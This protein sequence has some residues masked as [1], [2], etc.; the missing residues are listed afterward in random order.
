[1]RRA[2]S[3]SRIEPKLRGP[4]PVVGAG[5]PP[6]ELRQLPRAALS[7]MAA[8]GREAIECQRVL[9]KSGDN[10]VA[11][12]LEGQGTFYEWN[13]YP[14]GNVYDYESGAQYYY[15]AH[16]KGERP[17]EHGH[18]HAFLRQKGM[19]PGVRPAVLPGGTAGAEGGDALTHLIAVAM[20]DK[21]EAIQLFTTNRWVTGETWYAAA[22]VSAML[23]RFVIDLA[24]PSWTVNRWITAVVRLFRPQIAAL[25]VERDR[26]VA[27]WQ[28]RNPE[29][30]AFEDRRLEVA[31]KADISI[32]EQT[33]RVLAA[34]KRAPR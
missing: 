10:V 24:R 13:H 7:E 4:E 25:L 1:M 33:G 21:G 32:A 12:L 9:A 20:S 15:H 3:S 8:A 14:T 22:D 28:R 16:P 11:R 17:G 31:S 2:E 5:A 18:F 34:L 26:V 19:P 27:A 6:V 29:G 23:E 30:Q